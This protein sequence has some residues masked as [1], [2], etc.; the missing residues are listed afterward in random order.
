MRQTGVGKAFRMVDGFQLG[1]YGDDLSAAKQICPSPLLPSSCGF[2]C[3]NGVVKDCFP[4]VY[5]TL[6]EQ[7]N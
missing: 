6:E 7:T 2:V 4:A 3:S 5:R 1:R